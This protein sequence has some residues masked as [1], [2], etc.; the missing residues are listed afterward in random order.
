MDRHVDFTAIPPLVAGG[1]AVPPAFFISS[2]PSSC[3]RMK[4]I[5]KSFFDNRQKG[6]TR[7][8]RDDIRDPPRDKM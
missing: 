5:V 1:T 4:P 6:G 7:E 8:S 2:S 3:H